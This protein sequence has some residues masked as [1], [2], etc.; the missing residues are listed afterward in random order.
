MNSDCK[1]A[2]ILFIVLN[3]PVS[4]YVSSWS[5]ITRTTHIITFLLTDFGLVGIGEGTPYWSNILEDYIKVVS[6]A[7]TIRGLTLSDS[8]NKLRLLEYTEFERKRSINYGAYLALET[9]LLNA[10]CNCNKV[11]HEAELL[12]GGI[13]RTEIP[14]AYT[15]FLNHPKIMA[16]K[17]GE[18]IKSGYKQVKFKIPRNLEELER[19]LKILHSVKR[20]YGHEE[21]VL[22]ADANECFSTFEKAE[23][24][25]L[26]MDRYGV[27]IVE[28]PMPRDMLKDIAKLRKRFY[29]SLEIMLDESLGKP[30]DVELFAQMEVAD[31][32]NF[33]PS[34]LGCLTITREAILNA[35]R[36]GMKANIGSAF[37]TEI[38][39][40][41][42]LN[43][44]ASIPRLDYPLEEPGLCN[45]YGYSIVQEPP[46]IT[47]G[48]IKLFNIDATDLDFNMMKKFLMRSLFKERLLGEISKRTRFA[49]ILRV[50]IQL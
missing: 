49:K 11:K 43:L 9:A 46:M 44:A 16:R 1:I 10:L 20:Q 8:L 42:Y 13:Y 39:F 2:K 24:A 3:F 38:G 12:G 21:V 18:A 30:S 31:I 29:P 35:Q 32:I 7:K 48:H 26:I 6:L 25:L 37:M 34:K 5:P 4:H 33:H 23:R 22:R 50:H 14:I 17:L 45:M 27:N 41:H 40:S 36:L 15:I 19:M 47:N 28:Q